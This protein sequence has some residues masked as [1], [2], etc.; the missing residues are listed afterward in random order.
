MSQLHMMVTITN[1]N[2]AKKFVHFYK[3]KGLD[4]SAVTVGMGTAA[5]E[6]LDYF[7]LEGKREECTV[8]Y[9]YQ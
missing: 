8:S 1:R 6:I 9:C 7:G 3:E 4:I 5:S 2:L